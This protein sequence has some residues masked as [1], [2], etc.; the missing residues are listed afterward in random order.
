[1]L[2]DQAGIV[3]H[4]GAFV[5]PMR[6]QELHPAVAHFPIALLPAAIIAD[7]VGVAKD[8]E[9]MSEMGRLLMP[10]AVASMALTGVLGFAAQ[11]GVRTDE[12]SEQMLIT[13]RTLNVSG[14]I[15]ALALAA[16]RSRTSRPGPAYLAAGLGLSALLVYSGYLGGRMVYE[17]GVGV[18]T[19][20][21]LQKGRA[22]QFPGES[23]RTSAR[24]TLADT[25]AAMGQMARD[26][27]SGRLVPHFTESRSSARKRTGRSRRAH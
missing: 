20:N 19:A 11:G 21:G 6:L 5:M 24:L 13:H 2:S 1:L 8:D 23:L 18:K 15:A 25:G 14:L 26:T 17:H 3:R 10:A 27:V 16:L 12:K 22:P 9:R 7:A 4:F